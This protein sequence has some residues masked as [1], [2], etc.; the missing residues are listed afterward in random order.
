MFADPSEDD[1]HDPI[2]SQ[3]GNE[4]NSQKKDGNEGSA[5]GRLKRFST[6]IL[7]KVQSPLL[8]A[9]LEPEQPKVFV[10][11]RSRQI[12]VPCASLKARRDTRHE[13]HG[14]WA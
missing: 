11:T 4:G 2:P 8:K 6:K 9:P 5:T 1:S 12:V 13:A 7:R 3:D 14:Q 10:P